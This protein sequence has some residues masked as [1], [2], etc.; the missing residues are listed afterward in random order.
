[1]PGKANYKRKQYK[2]KARAEFYY[3]RIKIKGRRGYAD[4]PQYNAKRF[5]SLQQRK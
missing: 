3:N 1:M 5:Y 4:V 2:N